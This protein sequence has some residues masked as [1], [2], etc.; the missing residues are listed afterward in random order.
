MADR[1]PVPLTDL[2]LLTPLRALVVGPTG[3]GKSNLIQLLALHFQHLTTVSPND[4]LFVL[5]C[6]QKEAPDVN[7]LPA[8]CRVHQGLPQVDQVVLFKQ[9]HH[10]DELILVLDDLLADFVSLD[11]E[12]TRSYSSLFVELSRKLRISVVIL[13][14][15]FFPN[16]AALRI[17]I[18]NVTIVIL[19]PFPSDRLGLT[20]FLN[21][22]FS[23]RAKLALSA[24]SH[25]N[26]LTS[27]FCG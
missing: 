16:S 20:K 15:D 19:Y 21:K 5:Y 7:K 1:A 3:T 23:S 11:K 26:T 14:Q 10:I 12:E 25:A 6:Y 9:Q 18:K 24:L 22:I 8:N 27:T 4:K 2:K 17:F 13:L